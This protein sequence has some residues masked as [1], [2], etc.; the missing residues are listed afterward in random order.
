MEIKTNGKMQVYI[1]RHVGDIVGDG[2]VLVKRINGQ[3]WEIKCS[4]CGN[5][6]VGQPSNTSGHCVK[7]AY[8]ISGMAK[9]LHNESPHHNKSAS[10]LYRIW[11]G[12]KARCNTPTASHYEDYGGRNIKVDSE[13]NDYIKFKDWALK[14]GYAD[15]LTL[16]RVDTDGDYRPDNCRWVT[17]KEQMRNTRHNVWITYNGETKTIAEWA[18]ITGIKYH[19]LKARV[20]KHRDNV[21]QIFAT[22]IREVA[23]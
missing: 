19:T 5:V 16:D 9:R 6:F 8:R 12:M 3:K 2:A 20:K 13:W 1:R 14:N 15:N 18:E 7:C 22:R 10:R 21:E 4:R 11:L 17:Q 23:K